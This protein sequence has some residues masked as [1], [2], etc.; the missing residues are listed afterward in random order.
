MLIN[1]LLRGQRYE[2]FDVSFGLTDHFAPNYCVDIK[3][4]RGVI[5]A[6]HKF[7]FY[8]YPKKID[9]FTFNEEVETRLLSYLLIFNFST[10]HKF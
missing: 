9:T 1:V 6:S 2:V 4:N 7:F 3:V 10:D 8:L 5:I